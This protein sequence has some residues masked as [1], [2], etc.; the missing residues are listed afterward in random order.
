M[1]GDLETSI[2]MIILNDEPALHAPGLYPM[3][4]PSPQPLLLR[5]QQQ[6]L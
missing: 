5:R 6:P 2:S 4:H 1:K 3:S